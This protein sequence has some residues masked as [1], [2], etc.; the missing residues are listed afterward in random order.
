MGAANMDHMVFNTPE[1]FDI[2]R[3][4]NAANLTFGLGGHDC[5]AKHLCI[6]MVIATCR[7]LIDKFGGIGLLQQEIRYESQLNV[8]MAIE[9]WVTL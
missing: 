7:Y 8:K 9:L 5:I 2:E 6:N 1:Y 4:N 3:G